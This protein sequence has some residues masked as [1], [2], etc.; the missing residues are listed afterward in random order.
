MELHRL[1]AQESSQ[2]GDT[3]FALLVGCGL[4]PGAELARRHAHD[5]HAHEAADSAVRGHEEP[6]GHGAGRYLDVVVAGPWTLP[7]SPAARFRNGGSIRLDF[8]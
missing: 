3:G 8:A 6:V 7:L 2:L 5:H 4:A 1:P